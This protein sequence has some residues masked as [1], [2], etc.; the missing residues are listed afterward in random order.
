MVASLEKS[1]ADSA[2]IEPGMFV[3]L[4]Q[5]SILWIAVPF[6]TVTVVSY[7]NNTTLVGKSSINIVPLSISGTG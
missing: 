4:S 5:V 3:F 7:T 6:P 2:G 1:T